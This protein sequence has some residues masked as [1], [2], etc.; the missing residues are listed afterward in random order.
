[1]ARPAD[2]TLHRRAA[3]RS[4]PTPRPRPADRRDRVVDATMYVFASVVGAATLVD[5]WELHPPWL[6]VVAIVV[7]IA[8][9]VSLHWRRTHPGAVG[10][11]VGA[12]S[13]RDPHGLRRAPRRHLQRGDPGARPRPRRHR[14]PRR[15]LGVREPAALPAGHEL[16]VRRRGQPAHGRRR[17]RLGALRARAARARAVAARPGRPR[18]GRG[19]R[20]RAAADRARDARRARPPPLA[21]LRPRRRA[22]V[23]PRRPA[24]GGR[25]GGRRHPR[26]RARRARRAARRDRRPARGRRRE[27]HASRPS[28]RSPTSP[29]SSRSRGRPG[30]GSPRRSSWATRRRPPPSAAPPTGSRRRV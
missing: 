17:A 24:R 13:T 25:R 22:R 7:G 10:I 12:V 6:R 28:R 20:G 18:R 21:A 15:R 29:P 27:P 23:P 3:R 1:M 11:G 26:E 19:A 16:P 2:I 8:T 4:W 30:C 14:R 5:T 9:V